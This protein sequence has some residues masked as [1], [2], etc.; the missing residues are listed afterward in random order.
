M[1]AGKTKHST[2]ILSRIHLV[3]PEVESAFVLFNGIRVF[4]VHDEMFRHGV[5]DVLVIDPAD[6]R[7][8]GCARLGGKHVLAPQRGITFGHDYQFAGVL[9]LDFLTIAVNEGEVDCGTLVE[10]ALGFQLF[11]V[12]VL[13]VGN[14]L[15]NGA[16]TTL[17]EN[18][19]EHVGRLTWNL[20]LV[21]V[22][23]ALLENVRLEEGATSKSDRGE[24]HVKRGRH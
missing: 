12:C 18:R 21:L 6:A 20:V 19:T 17:V 9:I 24:E 1:P 4:L 10:H 2:R 15:D 7:R 11:D 14:L 8:F 23:V 16:V 5:E 13:I 3:F 22:I